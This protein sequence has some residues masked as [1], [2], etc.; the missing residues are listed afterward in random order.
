MPS[1]EEYLDN[2]LKG[3]NGLEEF[4]NV[5]AGEK[6]DFSGATIEEFS[7]PTRLSEESIRIDDTTTMTE[8]DIEK[9]LAEGEDSLS[10]ESETLSTGEPE[11]LMDL[12]RQENDSELQEI[13]ELLQKSDNNEP[14]DE[15]IFALLQDEP[16]TGNNLLDEIMY[17][18]ENHN[19]SIINEKSKR[20][21]ERKRERDERRAQKLAMKEAKKTAKLEAKAAREAE[22]KV[23]KGLSTEEKS[24]K[25]SEAPFLDAQDEQNDETQ[26]SLLQ[27]ELSELD[28]LL[29]MAANAMNTEEA[30]NTVEKVSADSLVEK[31]VAEKRPQKQKLISRIVNLLTE[32]VED[33]ESSKESANEDIL[34]SDENKNIIDE[35][36][37]DKGKKKKGKK[38]KKAIK[39][40]ENNSEEDS[41]EGAEDKKAK[42]SRKEKKPK[43]EKVPKAIIVEEGEHSSGGK[44]SFKKI[45][46]I[47]LVCLS[48]MAII[49]LVANI[50][51]DYSAK[52][53]GKEAYYN[54]DYQSCYQNLYGMDLNESEQVMY[55]R[56]ESILR[57]RLWI[58]EYELFAEEGAEAE[59]LDSL[60]QSVND[61]SSLYDFAAQWNAASDVEEHY[62]QILSILSE[63]YHL[64]EAQALAIAAIN[65]DADYSK[66][67]YDIVDGEGFG[68]WNQ[69]AETEAEILPDILPEE[70]ELGDISF[71]DNNN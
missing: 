29:N 57:I 47:M 25:E 26:Q 53:A 2:L 41:E 69:S 6:M 51:G 44:L 1:Q 54:G 62:A 11:D 39:G 31:I 48:L 60:I 10:E 28:E 21:A 23:R 70:E 22:K 61:Y 34:L 35:L 24:E 15:D 50:S 20:A 56:S 58:R 45:L 3:L 52:Q 9:L 64:T 63:K 33:E 30:D 7:E 12:L 59:A 40:E 32:E 27:N 71:V 4:D 13:Q 17:S 68:S 5:D 49:I 14:I 8:E 46:P 66:M 36:D 43:K 37:K 18:S 16:D 65:N 67:I 19:E 38:G 55:N 42:K